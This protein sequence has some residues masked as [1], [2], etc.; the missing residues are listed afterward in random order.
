[1]PSVAMFDK[2]NV[3][4]REKMDKNKRKHSN[5]IRHHRR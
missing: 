3:A 1:V 2:F 5:K 4:N